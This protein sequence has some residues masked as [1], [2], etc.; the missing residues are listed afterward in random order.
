MIN[1]Q[2]VTPDFK[3]KGFTFLRKAALLTLRNVSSTK[4]QS[5]TILICDDKYIRQLNSQYR[6]IDRPTDVLS[7]SSGVVLPDSPEI[8]LGDIAI[9]FETA[10]KQAVLAGHPVED[11]LSL[12]VIHGVLHL[13]GYD[14]HTDS[15]KKEM[16]FKQTEVLQQM[17]IQMD[18][19]SGDTSIE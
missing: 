10:L 1:I 19:F 14:H 6:D 2:I 7:F 9:S 4:G 11:E 17:N 5:L 18:H 13:A 12:L 15:D 3:K 8:Y 16:W